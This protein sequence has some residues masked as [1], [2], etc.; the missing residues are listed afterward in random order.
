M[1]FVGKGVVTPT[2]I[3]LYPPEAQTSNFVL[4][5]FPKQTAE[6]RFLRVQFW[7]EGSRLPMGYEAKTNDADLN[8]GV[9]ARYRRVM[10][11]GLEFAGRRY[12]AL[13]FQ[14]HR[15][16]KIPVQGSLAKKYVH[17]WVISQKRKL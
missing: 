7:H 12:W 6:G 4:R 16:A 2:R 10:N 5:R 14:L 13:D 17:G 1:V 8:E 9:L 11:N 3:L 15:Q